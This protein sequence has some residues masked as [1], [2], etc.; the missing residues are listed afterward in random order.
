MRRF[1]LVPSRAVRRVV[2]GSVVA[3]ALLA[4]AGLPEDGH[5]GR[6][7][8][9]DG[10]SGRVAADERADRGGSQRDHPRPGRRDDPGPRPRVPHR[11]PLRRGGDGQEGA[12]P[13][14]DRRGAV[15]GGPPVGEGAPGRG[16]RLAPQGRGIQGCAR[17]PRRN[18]NSTGP[19][20]VL[21]QIQ[22]RRN[23]AL[24]LA[25]GGIG[26]G[27]RQDR[28]RPQALGIAGRGRPRPPRPG[29]D[30]LRRRDRLGP[31]AGLWPRRPPSATPS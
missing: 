9:P 2:G 19:R 12:A 21:A 31:G 22:E 4:L 10:R 13:A 8:G 18:W 17:S 26:R 28:G 15:P 7:S 23:R 1:D 14:G 11:A 5:P 6:P 20:L 30:R 3:L 25:E 27:S 29:Q 16:R 24:A